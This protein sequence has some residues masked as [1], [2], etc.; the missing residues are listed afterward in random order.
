MSGHDGEELIALTYLLF[1]KPW[2]ASWPVVRIT[3]AAFVLGVDIIADKS[4]IRD[5]INLDIVRAQQLLMSH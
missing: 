4:A 1:L 2:L 5:K 3:S